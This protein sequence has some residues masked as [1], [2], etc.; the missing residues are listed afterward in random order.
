MEEH[1]LRLATWLQRATTA[2]R[3]LGRGVGGLQPMQQRGEQSQV[4]SRLAPTWA[5]LRLQNT[6]NGAAA[7]G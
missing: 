5:N 4:G 3:G 6:V 1:M 2:G 7:A